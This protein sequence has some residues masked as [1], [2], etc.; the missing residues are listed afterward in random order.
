M[1]V[2]IIGAGAIG[3][4]TAYELAADGH[5]VTVF[6]RRSAA[7]EEASFAH[8]GLIAPWA[9]PGLADTSSASSLASLL[10]RPAPF[11]LHWPLGGS[12]LAWLWQWR[13]TRPPGAAQAQHARL[14]NLTTYSQQR[15]HALRHRL[16]LE[17]DR[18]D[19][20]LVLLRSA[21]DARLAEAHLQA[22]RDAGL[23]FTQIDTAA[24]RLIEPALCAETGFF[25]A[26]HLPDSEAS[27][28]RQFTM[29][30]KAEAQQ[31]GVQF[32]FNR[33]V[34]HITPAPEATISIADESAPRHFDAVVVC[35]GLA[36]ATLLKPLGL[37]IPLATVYGYSVTASIREP[38]NAPVSAVVDAQHRVA[39]VRLG[40]RVR[41][42]GGAAIGGHPERKNPTAI[43]TLYKVLHDWFPGAALRNGTEQE[44][45]AARPL[46]PDGAPLLGPSGL[47]GIWLNLG[48]GGNGWAQAC[49][50]ARA[51]ADSLAGRTPEVDLDGLGIAR[52]QR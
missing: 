32:E 47:P 49:G 13:K 12:D 35:A 3:V 4:C 43:A 42:A 18:S 5:Q 20:T 30:L 9:A 46:L 44:W 37:R 25:G 39:I 45:K 15:L 51:T 6:E 33:T 1:K 24:A 41:V 27:N 22:L 31:L 34:A 29:L 48:H 40:Q 16:A 11:Q 17:Y 26:I 19:G 21:R 38:L 7:A 50:S 28:C 2:A 52:L 23:P 10:R 8:A 14:H 36:S